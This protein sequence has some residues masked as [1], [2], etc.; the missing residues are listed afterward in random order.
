MAEWIEWCIALIQVCV[1]WLGSIQLLG[2]SVMW[3]ILA[4]I[5]V[6]LIVRA[7]IFHL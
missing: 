7:A 6:S 2:V 4:S 3:I 5:F 1:D